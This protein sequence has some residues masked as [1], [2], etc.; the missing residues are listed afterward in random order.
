ML[1]ARLLHQQRERRGRRRHARG[2]RDARQVAQVGVRW[3]PSDVTVCVIVADPVGH[4]RHRDRLRRLPVGRREGQRARTPSPCPWLLLAGVTVTS[5]VGAWFSLHGVCQLLVRG[6]QVQRG[7]RAQRQACAAVRD[8]RAR[9]RAASPGP[10]D[11]CAWRCR[12]SWNSSCGSVLRVRDDGDGPRGRLGALRD[13][14]RGQRGRRWGDA[15]MLDRQPRR[16]SATASTRRGRRTCPPSPSPPAPA[17]R[18]A[19]YVA[20]LHPRRA[21]DVRR[22]LRPSSPRPRSSPSPAPWPR[23]PTVD[24]EPPRS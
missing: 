19:G 22:E 12:R 8:P 21:R 9:P 2:H 20:A 23:A 16:A 7:I 11:S 4:A 3:C 13:G 10:C 14:E 24:S 1:S 18:R 5:A 6:Q 15:V 17:P